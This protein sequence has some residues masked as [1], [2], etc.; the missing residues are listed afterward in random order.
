MRTT[1]SCL[2]TAGIVAIVPSYC[3]GQQDVDQGVEK[4]AGHVLWIIPNFRTSPELREYKPIPS[5][6]KF[7]LAAQDTF[8]R[9]HDRARGGVCR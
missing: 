8:D 1:I 3:F 9:R 4:P 5:S 6:E 7:R 2:V